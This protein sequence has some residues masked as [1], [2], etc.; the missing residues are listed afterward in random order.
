[1]YNFVRLLNTAK[2]TVKPYIIGLDEQLTQVHT[3]DTRW[4]LAAVSEVLRKSARTVYSN[5]F[6]VLVLWG[7]LHQKY[8]HAF[9]SHFPI[10]SRSYFILCIFFLHEIC[11][12]QVIHF[13]NSVLLLHIIILFA[14]VPFLKGLSSILSSHGWMSCYFV[15]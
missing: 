15:L 14:Q 4:Q 11:L 8:V 12:L 2:N 13:Y 9:S 7:Q 6:I 1:M 5:T 10:D 3:M